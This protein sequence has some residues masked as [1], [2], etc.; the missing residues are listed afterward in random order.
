MSRPAVWWTAGLTVLG[1]LAA[2]LIFASVKPDSHDVRIG[3][4]YGAPDSPALGVVWGDCATGAPLTVEESARQVVITATV[5]LPP[6]ASCPDIGRIDQVS[7]HNPLGE[8]E[9]ID[10]TTGMRVDV[11]DPAQG[12]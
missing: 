7:L 1:M 9:V 12:P 8:R 6:D 2:V 4:V 11:L 5:P 10:G 3:S